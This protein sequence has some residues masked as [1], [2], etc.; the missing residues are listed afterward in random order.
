[1]VTGLN[2]PK[3]VK[4][5]TMSGDEP[6]FPRNDLE[7]LSYSL[8][9]RNIGCKNMSGLT[10]RL[11]L[12][13]VL[14]FPLSLSFPSLS[15]CWV[16]LYDTFDDDHGL[17]PSSLIYFNDMNHVL[18]VCLINFGIVHTYSISMPPYYGE[19]FFFFCLSL[20]S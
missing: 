11:F 12:T 16:S 13:T 10:L 6:W 4:A 7:C 20:L 19:V 1:M 3:L 8:C 2:S 15:V 5:V 18:L 17:S 9:L 14:C